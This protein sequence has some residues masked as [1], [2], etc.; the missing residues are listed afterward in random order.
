MHGPDE[1]ET[2]EIEG[3]DPLLWYDARGS[4]TGDAYPIANECVGGPII[5]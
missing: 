4:S 2:G 3:G 5:G 1:A